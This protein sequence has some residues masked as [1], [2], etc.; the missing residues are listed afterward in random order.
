MNKNFI[1]H[2]LGLIKDQAKKLVSGKPVIIPHHMMGSGAG[3]HI[4]LLKPQNAR[5][6]L[7]AYKKGKGFKLN[8]TPDELHHT[9]IHGNGFRD[10]LNKASKAVKSALGHP[11]VREV[12]KTGV[13]YG[14]DA[15]GAAVGNAVGSPEAGMAVGAILG[16]AGSAAIDNRSINAGKKQLVGDLKQKGEEIAVD[17]LESNI[18]RL[19]P[20][21]QPVAQEALKQQSLSAFGYGIKNHHYTTRKGDIVHHIGHHYVREGNMPYSGGKLKKGSAEAKAF[22]ASIRKKKGSKKSSKEGGK[23]NIKDIFKKAGHYLIPAATSALGGVAGTAVGGPLGGI[24]G[25]AA[26]S[27]AGH[28]IDQKLGIGI[29][30]RGR[31][32]KV[33]GALASDSSAYRQ[34]MRNNFGLE[35]TANTPNNE[36]VKD[37]KT[38]PRVKPSSTE[39]TLSPYAGIN[40]P[41]MNPFIPTNYTQMGGTN[42]GYGGRGLYGASGGNGLY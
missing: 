24:A 14:A 13:R 25:S 38:N 36:P 23:I 17:A 26:G 6:L 21:L 39:M 10:I 12:A 34:A 41:A 37:F 4:V 32:R 5:K 22:M 30:K 1:P 2:Q 7:T 27:Y 3:N 19:P 28:E 31:P 33:G 20:K 29:R 11:A 16:S 35:L 9:I 42:C 40:S 8:L 15:V 18:H